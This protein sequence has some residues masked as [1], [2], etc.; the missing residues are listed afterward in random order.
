MRVFRGLDQVSGISGSKVMPKVMPKVFQI[1]Q[2]YPR[3]LMWIS[4]INILRFLP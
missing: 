2:E 3:E 1:C 4:L